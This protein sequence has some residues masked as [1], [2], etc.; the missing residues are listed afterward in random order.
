MKGKD[1][2]DQSVQFQTSAGGAVVFALLL[3]AETF[4][5]WND[6]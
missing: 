2:Q 4:C 6:S 1:Q 3:M 5:L